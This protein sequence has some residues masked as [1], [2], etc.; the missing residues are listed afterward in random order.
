MVAHSIDSV[1]P[2]RRLK[3]ELAFGRSLDLNAMAEAMAATLNACASD[4]RGDV[5]SDAV[6]QLR[7]RNPALSPL[8]ISALVA[9]IKARIERGAF[10]RKGVL[11]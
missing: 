11:E 3:P 6:A 5:L 9:A 2:S 8:D 7:R 10:G 4:W 1:F